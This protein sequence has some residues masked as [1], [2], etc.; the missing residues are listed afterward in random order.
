MAQNH[1]VVADLQSSLGAR[2]T[3][4]AVANA[5]IAACAV[6]GAGKAGLT[7]A[8]KLVARRQM[9]QAF[10]ATASKQVM[11]GGARGAARL[12]VALG[13]VEFGIDQAQTVAKRRRGELSDA[14]YKLETG[15]NAGSAAGG[16]GGSIG[17]AAIGTAI[18]P[19]PG[20]I[21]GAI[22]GG[23]AGAASGRKL[24]RAVVER[25]FD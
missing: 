6:V 7:G 5:R 16:V 2:F 9:S 24:G 8:S 11:K 20:T 17:G 19:G 25:F 13:A 14:E 1:S 21:L 15:G 18:L 3:K 22:A 23:F 10:G 4:Q 12:S